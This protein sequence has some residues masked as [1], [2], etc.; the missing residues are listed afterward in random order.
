VTRL[1]RDCGEEYGDREDT[2]GARREED[3]LLQPRAPVLEEQ[4]ELGEERQDA[5]FRCR[6]IRRGCGE[7]PDDRRDRGRGQRD[8]RAAVDARRVEE[9]GSGCVDD[10]D[11]R[12][13]EPEV[14]KRADPHSGVP[15]PG[16]NDAQEDRLRCPG[17]GERVVGQ[18]LEGR[19]AGE[20]ERRDS[21]DEC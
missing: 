18:E 11:V 17:E 15:E 3:S 7:P 9:H 10:E 13:R 4:A 12:D 5:G 6:L 8:G 16:R 20:R 1:E 21:D 2:E 14:C 19:H